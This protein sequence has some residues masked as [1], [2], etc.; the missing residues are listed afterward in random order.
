M[1]LVAQEAKEGVGVNSPPP[2][3]IFI[4]VGHREFTTASTADAGKA[5][6]K[7][8]VKVMIAGALQL[9]KRMLTRLELRA[10]LKIAHRQ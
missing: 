6:L 3:G 9:A 10:L 4:G 8:K 1:G 2:F 5:G 7:N